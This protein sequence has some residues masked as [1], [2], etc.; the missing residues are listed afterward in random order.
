VRLLPQS[1]RALSF[2]AAS[3]GVEPCAV[4]NVCTAELRARPAE[5]PPAADPGV[6]TAPTPPVLLVRNVLCR[7]VAEHHAAV[8]A[9]VVRLPP[10]ALARCA[11]AGDWRM[12][13]RM[14]RRRGACSTSTA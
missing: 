13:A 9:A 3:I 6:R 2:D 14:V 12:R 5:Q 1:F 4:R 8:D 7:A 10:F 11:P